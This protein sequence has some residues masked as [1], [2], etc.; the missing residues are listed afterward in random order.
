[1]FVHISYSL[2]P[3]EAHLFHFASYLCT[4]AWF[5]EQIFGFA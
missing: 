4:S 3:Q 5:I 1:M 2:Q